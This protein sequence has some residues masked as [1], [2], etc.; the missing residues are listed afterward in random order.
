MLT[1]RWITSQPFVDDQFTKIRRIKS[2]SGSASLW[3]YLP[4]LLD[5]FAPQIPAPPN[6]IYFLNERKSHKNRWNTFDRRQDEILSVVFFIEKE[7]S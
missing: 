1:D 6:A 4:E 5:L 2:N 7:R 3:I